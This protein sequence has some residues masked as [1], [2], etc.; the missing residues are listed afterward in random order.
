MNATSMPPAGSGI[1][2][3][4]LPFGDLPW[5]VPL[6][7]AETKVVLR[8]ARR[9]C[10]NWVEP[11]DGLEYRAE[12]VAVSFLTTATR[13]LLVRL[14]LHRDDEA[15]NDVDGGAELPVVYACYAPGDFRP[16]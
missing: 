9:H 8:Q 13:Y 16:L 3:L 6:S 12:A 11:P 14:S 7:E 2:R 5:P 10:P 15:D 4:P 1:A